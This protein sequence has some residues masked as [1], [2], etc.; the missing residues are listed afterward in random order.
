MAAFEATTKALRQAGFGGGRSVAFYSVRDIAP[1]DGTGTRRSPISAMEGR[2]NLTS[3]NRYSV[4]VYSYAP[5]SHEKPSESGELKVS[6][7]A[8]EL[9]FSSETTVRL[10]SRYD[11]NRFIFS[12]EQ[13]L[14]SLPAGLRFSV[15]VGNDDN[16]T[17]AE[18]RGGIVIEL[19]LRGSFLLALY[20][21]VLIALGTALPAII[22]AYAANKISFGL[23]VTMFASAL[24]TGIGTVFP[25]FR[26]P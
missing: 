24:L 14:L 11:L 26:K 12:T 23:A 8:T 22:G 25:A 4:D 3:G 21:I 18:D 5:D 10:D 7:D 2:Y 16:E 19:F 1:V 20:R 9:R 17:K 13:R 15:Q 6:S